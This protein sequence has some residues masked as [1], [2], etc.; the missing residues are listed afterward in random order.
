MIIYSETELLDMG[1]KP[2]NKFYSGEVYP[3]ALFR[4][5]CIELNVSYESVKGL[6]IGENYWRLYLKPGIEKPFEDID[7]LP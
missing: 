6:R 7:L 4:M 1:L 3:F 5:H 2:T